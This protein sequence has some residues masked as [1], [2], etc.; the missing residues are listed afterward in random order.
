MAIEQERRG[1]RRFN[2]EVPTE[3]DNS[4]NGSGFTEDVS[5]SGVRVE[6]ASI[7]I[8]PDMQLGLRFSFYHGSFETLF[9]GTVVRR[10]DQGFAVRFA[11]LDA[12]Q[13]GVLRRA[14]SLSDGLP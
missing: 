1:A 3:Y 7:A 11:D 9:K 5:L 13:L 4:R 2:I 8:S 14:L 6:H 10:T 12:D